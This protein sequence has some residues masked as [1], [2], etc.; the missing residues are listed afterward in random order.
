MKREKMVVSGDI[1]CYTLGALSPLEAIDTCICMGASISAGL[2]FEKGN[3]EMRGKVVSVIGDSTFFHSGMT[4]LADVVYNGGSTLTVILD[5][6]TTA[7][8]GHQDNPGTGRTLKGEYTAAIEIAPL[9]RA[10]GVKRVREVDPYDLKTLREAIREEAK[11]GEPSVIVSRR[12]CV[13]L[14]KSDKGYYEING[15]KCTAC[16]ACMVLGCPAITAGESGMTID[17]SLCAGCGVCVQV[18]KFNAI[19]KAGGEDEK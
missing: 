9:C 17:P 19:K 12:A 8:T 15:E 18:C 6:R 4:G 1:G 10:L 3:P 11:A 16:K 2:G 14:D 7:M 13:L 5:N